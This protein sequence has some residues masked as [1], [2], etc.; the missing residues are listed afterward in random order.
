MALSNLTGMDFHHGQAQANGK[1][2][3]GGLMVQA[4]YRFRRDCMK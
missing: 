1:L 4:R 3:N 2:P